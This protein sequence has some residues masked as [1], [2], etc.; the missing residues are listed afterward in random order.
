MTQSKRKNPSATA[1]IPAKKSGSGKAAPAKAVSGKMASRNAGFDKTGS[2]KTEPGKPVPDKALLNKAPY[3]KTLPTGKRRFN[4]TP[5]KNTWGQSGADK[6][7]AKQTDLNTK[8]ACSPQIKS[9]LPAKAEKPVRSHQAETALET[10]TKGERIAKHLA[11]AGV[12]SRREAERLILAGR[13][14]VNGK[15]LSSPALNVNPTDIIKV[16]GKLVGSAEETRLWRYHK[17]AGTLTTNYDPKGRPTIF[18]KLPEN[19]PRVVTV[20]RLDY[21]TEGLLL[22][23]ND[24]E[25]ARHLELP[26]NAWLRHYRVRVYGHVDEKKLKDLEN[27]VTIEGVHYEPIK[28]IVETDKKEGTNTWLSISIRE[29]KNRE[30]RKVMEFCGLTVTRLL[31]TSFG[32]FQL[33]KLQRGSIEEVPRRALKEALGQFFS[34]R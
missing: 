25:L 5:N 30:V 19:L 13:V 7:A 4:K 27:G 12:A 16:D 22:L 31:R 15:V 8:T 18:D 24:G 1:V 10:E 9:S 17:T 26:K 28:V 2:G 6:T 32:P 11:R 23:T 29:G 21:N 14:S 34:S 33:A 20:G 3:D